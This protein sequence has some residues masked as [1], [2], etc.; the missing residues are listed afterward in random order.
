MSHFL[1]QPLTAGVVG[2][3]FSGGCV[4]PSSPLSLPALTLLSRVD[5]L[6][7]ESTCV[8]RPSAPLDGTLPCLFLLTLLLWLQTGPMELIDSGLLDDIK[9]GLAATC[10]RIQ[11]LMR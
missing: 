4:L 10:A 9:V 6:R 1:K 3:P 8:C 11:K 7:L 5:S 2:C